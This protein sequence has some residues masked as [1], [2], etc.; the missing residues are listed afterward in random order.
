MR[1]QRRPVV[2]G[3]RRGTIDHVVPVERRDRYE[4]PFGRLAGQLDLA[5]VGGDLVAHAGEHVVGELHLIHLVHRDDHVRHAQQARDEEVA[6]GLLGG[7]AARVHQ[8]DGH[9]GVRGGG[10]HVSCILH[11]AGRVGED[12]AP[13]RRGEVAPGDVDGDPLLA[14]GAQ[15]VGQ[16]RQIGAPEPA[17]AAHVLDVLQLVAHE[18]LGVVQK[19]PDERAL[20]VVDAP[21][22]GATEGALLVLLSLLLIRSNPLSSGLPSP[23]RWRGRRR[24]WR[25]A[26]ST[27]RPAPRRGWPPRRARCCGPRRYRSCPRRCGSGPWWTPSPRPAPG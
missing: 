1:E 20:A 19:P 15:P 6:T 3:H 27:S 12:E 23:P 17:P 26:R 10:H 2:P 4:R 11:V 18:R 24:A 14:L 22:G 13:P 25:L 8:D 16:E 21:G 7:P 5:G 9:V